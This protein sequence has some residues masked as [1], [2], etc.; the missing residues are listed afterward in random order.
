MLSADLRHLVAAAARDAGYPG[1]ERDVGLRDGGAP[2][3]YSS[4]LP[5]RLAPDP[6]ELA[7]RMATHLRTTAWIEDAQRTG[8]GYLTIT[9]TPGKLTETA[10]RVTETGPA[11][12][13][14]DALAGTSLPRASGRPPNQRAE[15]AGGQGSGC[16]PGDRPAR[17]RR[18]RDRDGA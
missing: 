5:L 11:C 10:V 13:R 17:G 3:R 18:G 9:V 14:S 16:R 7:A 4:S 12:A 6:A 1:H 15:L 2:G 8:H